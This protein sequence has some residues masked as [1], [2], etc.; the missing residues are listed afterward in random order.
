MIKKL[1]KAGELKDGDIFYVKS[2]NFIENN[3]HLFDEDMAEHT[4]YDSIFI[5]DEVAHV[6][7]YNVQVVVNGGLIVYL[8]T[9]SK[10]YVLGHY[11]EIL[12]D[13]DLI[14]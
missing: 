3:E 6:D 12:S 4:G 2:R 8:D 11:S 14:S 7:D 1:I 9:N 13:L 10:V 5:A